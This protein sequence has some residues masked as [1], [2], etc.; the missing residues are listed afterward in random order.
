MAVPDEML[1][2]CALAAFLVLL[3]FGE[4]R[5]VAWVALAG[6]LAR[7]GLWTAAAAVRDA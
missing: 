7:V 6:T 3:A 4:G 2:C 5:F 1:D